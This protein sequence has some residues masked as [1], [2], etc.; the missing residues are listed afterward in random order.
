MPRHGLIILDGRELSG[1]GMLEHVSSIPFF[2]A[3]GACFELSIGLRFRC[4]L[5]SIKGPDLV[6]MNL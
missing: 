6:P 5:L 2:R 1:R 4:R 3:R